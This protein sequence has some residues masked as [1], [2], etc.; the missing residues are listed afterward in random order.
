MNARSGSESQTHSYSPDI[1]AVDLEVLI[2]KGL[3]WEWLCDQVGPHSTAAAA[4]AAV[5]AAV[6][7][8]VAAAVAADALAT[9]TAATG[10]SEIDTMLSEKLA[11]VKL[12]ILS[13]EEE[14]PD[15][16]CTPTKIEET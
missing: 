5:A 7:A 14:V 4:A 3:Q 12:G 15:L 9:T 2:V 6:A 1:D 16:S 11:N 8:T 10:W 13:P